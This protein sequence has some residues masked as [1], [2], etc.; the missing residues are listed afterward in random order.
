MTKPHSEEIMARLVARGT[1]TP[2]QVQ[3]AALDALDWVERTLEAGMQIGV[4]ADGKWTAVQWEIP[5]LTTAL[6]DPTL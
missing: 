6:E 3:T 4:C 5:G 2:E 1:L